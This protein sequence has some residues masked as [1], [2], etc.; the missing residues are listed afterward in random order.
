M[1]PGTWYERPINASRL[2]P[3]SPAGSLVY[4][5]A[6]QPTA[7]KSGPP[8]RFAIRRTGNP[9]AALTATVSIS[10]TAVNGTDYRALGTTVLFPAG[11]TEAEVVITPIAD[12]LIEPTKTVTLTLQSGTGYDLGYANSATVNIFSDPPLVGISANDALASEPGTDTGSFRI[13]L[14]GVPFGAVTINY[15]VEG[16]A[17]P[18]V[19]RKR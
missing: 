12:G 4:V 7:Y 16:T 2:E 1:M 14:N 3:W 17:V 10:G 15:T 13:G 5:K 19:D 8:G 18:G 9:S 6:T 11:S